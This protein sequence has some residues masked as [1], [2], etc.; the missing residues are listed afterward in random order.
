MI[1]TKKKAILTALLYFFGAGRQNK[2]KVRMFGVR[3]WQIFMRLII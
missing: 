3:M 2:G 1:T